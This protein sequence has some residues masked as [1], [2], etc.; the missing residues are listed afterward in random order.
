MWLTDMVEKRLSNNTSW[1]IL[2]LCV[3][4]G[5]PPI[6]LHVWVNGTTIIFHQS[7]L[8]FRIARK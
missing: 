7:V 5:Y 4:Y 8:T 6:R 2:A 3:M 1:P